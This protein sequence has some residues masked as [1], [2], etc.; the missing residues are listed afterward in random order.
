MIIHPGDEYAGGGWAVVGGMSQSETRGWVRAGRRR[1]RHYMAASAA[2]A[3][4]TNWLT[5]GILSPWLSQCRVLSR[6]GLVNAIGNGARSI[7]VSL[8]LPL[9]LAR[10]GGRNNTDISKI[11]LQSPP[12]H[13]SRI[14]AGL[15]MAR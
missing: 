8:G 1:G 15:T 10:H 13:L 9:R 12:L 7:I 5:L 14:V 2:A 4:L 3:V 11:A 6:R